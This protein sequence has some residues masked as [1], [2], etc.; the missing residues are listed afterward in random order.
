MFYLSYFLS[1]FGHF[2]VPKT[3]YLHAIWSG[4]ICF[5]GSFLDCPIRICNFLLRTIYLSIYLSID[6]HDFYASWVMDICKTSLMLQSGHKSRHL[7]FIFDPHQ[8]H[9]NLFFIFVLCLL[10]FMFWKFWSKKFFIFLFFVWR[11]KLIQKWTPFYS[12]LVISN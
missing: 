5:E 12:F 3:L 7:D 1:L 9:G 10:W 4:F 6:G 8:I 2:L 11:G